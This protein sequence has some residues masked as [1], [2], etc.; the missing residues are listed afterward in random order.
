MQQQTLNQKR[1][2]L[3]KII[4]TNTKKREG[5]GAAPPTGGS[6]AEPALS[7]GTLPL[8]LPL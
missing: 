2:H 1:K 3:L 5:F 6:K 7:K 8:V 4:L